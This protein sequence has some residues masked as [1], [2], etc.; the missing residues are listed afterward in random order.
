MDATE[1]EVEEDL[2]DSSELHPAVRRPR[3]SRAWIGRR[4]IVGSSD[5]SARAAV[6]CWNP[7]D[8][9]CPGGRHIGCDSES[10]GDYCSKRQRR[11]GRAVLLHLY[12]RGELGP[13]AAG[14][15]CK[16][17]LNV[18]DAEVVALV[19]GDEHRGDGV[20]TRRRAQSVGD[21]VD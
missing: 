13:L 11:L 12:G 7:Q 2:V 21:V 5:S 3:I 6:K 19:V 8:A 14:Q 15:G 9:E 16:Q 1:T 10:I 20:A 4:Y 17:S 18:H